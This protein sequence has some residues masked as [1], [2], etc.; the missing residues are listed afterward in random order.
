LRLIDK[1]ALKGSV[2]P[3]EIYTCDLEISKL[4]LNK[5]EKDMVQLTA[6]EKR[7]DRVENRK[8]RNELKNKAFRG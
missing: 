6:K 7:R 5:K 2:V 1:V 4:P 8:R 3:V